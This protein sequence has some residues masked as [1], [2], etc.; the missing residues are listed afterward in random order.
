MTGNQVDRT[1][2]SIIVRNG[3][4]GFVRVAL[5]CGKLASG[6]VICCFRARRRTRDSSA[7]SS[8]DQAGRFPVGSREN[9]ERIGYE[10]T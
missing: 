4:E 3:N 5:K 8:A 1:C 9:L 2:A 6:R 7:R 10:D